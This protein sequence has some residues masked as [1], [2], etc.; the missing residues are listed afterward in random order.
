MSRTAT[1]VLAEPDKPASTPCPPAQRE[2]DRAIEVRTEG[3]S[4]P[5]LALMPRSSPVYA[6]SRFTRTRIKPFPAPA[7]SDRHEPNDCR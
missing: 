5:A 1:E 7:V 2:L 6:G 3:Q 4:V